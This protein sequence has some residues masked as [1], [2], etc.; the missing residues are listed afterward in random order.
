M[1]STHW[2]HE[3]KT[4]DGRRFDVELCATDTVQTVK[5]KISQKGG[6]CPCTQR[7]IFAGKE[8]EDGR[9]MGD[10]NIQQETSVH[11]LARPPSCARC[12]PVR[13]LRVP[14]QVAVPNKQ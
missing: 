3:I 13:A 9:T 11:L 6:G 14:Y 12:K 2:T 7:I 8:L 1:P 5:H 10:Y 4:L